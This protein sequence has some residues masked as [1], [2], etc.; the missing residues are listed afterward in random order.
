MI[1]GQDRGLVRGIGTAEDEHGHS[2]THLVVILAARAEAVPA[3]AAGLKRI[4]MTLKV[5]R[6]SASIL[7]VN[8][9]NN[10]LHFNILIWIYC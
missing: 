1:Q 6:L 5:H 7:Q 8:I 2:V 3:V 10:A 9:L 4:L